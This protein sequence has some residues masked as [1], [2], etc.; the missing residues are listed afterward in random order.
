[1]QRLNILI[2]GFKL[3]SAYVV[4]INYPYQFSYFRIQNLF[5]QNLCL[6][7]FAINY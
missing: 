7:K 4:R 6:F 3:L 5:L 2:W 1:M